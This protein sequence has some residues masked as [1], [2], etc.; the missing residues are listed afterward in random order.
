MD[1]QM[2]FYNHNRISEN[3]VRKTI[4]QIHSK[5]QHIQ[6]QNLRIVVCSNVDTVQHNEQ[7]YQKKIISHYFLFH[8]FAEKFIQYQLSKHI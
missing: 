7:T 3:F 5:F 1:L 2:T 4:P 6:L 8:W